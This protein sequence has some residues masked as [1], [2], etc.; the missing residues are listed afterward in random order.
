MSIRTS[1][2]FLFRLSG[3][4]RVQ[5]SAITEV[6]ALS[7]GYH[8]RQDALSW[9][10]NLKVI[11]EAKEIREPE[12]EDLMMQLSPL[13]LEKIQV[14]EQQGEMKGQQE[15]VLRQ[16][17]RQV[18]MMS[19]EVSNQVKALLFA[20]LEELGEALLDFSRMDDLLAWLD[21]HQD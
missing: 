16:L 3:K 18:G 11:P 19:P 20:R 7:P 8:G 13:F 4:D 14:A 15:L 12:E 9:L 5:S 17:T 21:A 2:N 6:A 1:P 10:G